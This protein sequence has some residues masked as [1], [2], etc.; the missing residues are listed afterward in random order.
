LHSWEF[1]N[2]AVHFL[3]QQEWINLPLNKSSSHFHVLFM[4][5][6]LNGE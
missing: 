6:C 2:S 3:R 1:S 4:K 5:S